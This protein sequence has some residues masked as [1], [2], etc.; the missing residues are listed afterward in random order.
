MARSKNREFFGFSGGVDERAEGKKSRAPFVIS[1]C[2][3]AA[4]AATAGAML[5]MS[6]DMRDLIDR[7]EVLWFDDLDK[8]DPLRR[9]LKTKT[10]EIKKDREIALKDPEKLMEQAKND[11]TEVVEL[12]N[13]V[14]TRDAFNADF[15]ET[16]LL[17]DLT[18]TANLPTDVTGL[19]PPRSLPGRTDGRGLLSDQARVKG[20]GLGTFLKDNAGDPDG[21]G[22]GGGG[23]GGILDFIPGTEGG[24]AGRIVYV[25]DVSASM[26]A[27]GL[28]KLELAKESL[29]D[30]IYQ[31]TEASTFNIVAF[32]GHVSEMNKEPVAA[33]EQGVK[34]ATRYLSGFTRESINKNLGTNTLAAL[35]KAC[36][37]QPDVIVLLTDG[38]PTGADGITVEI[39]PERIVD[40]FK[41]V[42][43]SKA[44]LH[45]VGLEIDDREGAPGAILLNR[46]AASA[47]GKVQFISRDDL[48]R[49]K[50]K[51]VSKR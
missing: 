46:L 37:M 15:E 6:G 21:G 38:L 1:M 51:L 22:G 45:I 48:L 28:Y 31:L 32:A 2:L 24:V 50:N 9:K 33:S 47:N 14:L 40:T 29:V 35:Q 44:S 20:N 16:D 17:P 39:G 36:A 8:K 23:T 27:A 19:S 13:R 43:K 49:F 25:L 30:H 42:N 4:L 18:T 34:R 41:R 3:H 5:W 7:G 10:V 26:S 12:S 11:R